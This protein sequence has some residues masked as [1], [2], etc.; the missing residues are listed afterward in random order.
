LFCRLATEAGTRD[1][2]RIAQQLSLLYDGAVITAYMDSDPGA[3]L[4]ARQIAE[5]LLD[6][7]V[8]PKAPAARPK[9]PSRKRT[10]KTS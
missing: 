3:P 9:K 7:Q 1:P 5:S 2:A 6:A 8:A 10:T 4:V